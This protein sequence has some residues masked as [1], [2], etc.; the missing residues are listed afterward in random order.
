MTP[1]A[2]WALSLAGAGLAL[3]VALVA[4][5]SHHS[6]GSHADQLADAIAHR[7][8]VPRVPTRR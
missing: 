3:V 6:V 5:I 4:F 8:D 1:L 2:I 7:S